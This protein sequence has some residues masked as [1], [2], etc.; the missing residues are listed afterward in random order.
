MDFFIGLLV[1]V[2]SDGILLHFSPLLR[3]LLVIF[4]Y[5]C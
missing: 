3:C 4:M 5:F 2:T 1:E